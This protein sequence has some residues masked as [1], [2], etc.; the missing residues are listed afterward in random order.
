MPATTAQALPIK[1]ERQDTMPSN[2]SSAT[3]VPYDHGWERP[4]SASSSMDGLQRSPST[5]LNR[6]V[7][8]PKSFLPSDTS[9]IDPMLVGLG[10]AKYMNSP[11][12]LATPPDSGSNIAGFNGFNSFN[13]FNNFDNNATATTGLRD[14]ISAAQLSRFREQ[15]HPAYPSPADSSSN[16]PDTQ[17]AI[18]PSYGG[19]QSTMPQAQMPPPFHGSLATAPHTGSFRR[20]EQ[21]APVTAEHRSKRMRLSPMYDLSKGPQRYNGNSNFPLG[22]AYYQNA[23]QRSPQTLQYR[24]YSPA[25]SNVGVPLT[26]SSSSA[27][28]DENHA[29][30]SAKPSPAVAQDSPDLRRVSVNSLLSNDDDTVGDSHSEGPLPSF[31]HQCT[32]DAV[33]QT[34]PYG[35]DRGLPD[36]DCP[37][38]NDSIALD[39]SSNGFDE[40]VNRPTSNGAMPAAEFGFGYQRLNTAHDRGNYYAKPVPVFIP[41]SLEPLPAT[42]L[43]NPMNMLYFHHFLHHTA[44]ILVP[45]DC[46]ENPFKSIL[47]QSRYHNTIQ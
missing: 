34:V 16:F 46:S 1:I 44:R 13:S 45:H 32:T 30:S 15:I 18:G 9:A 33:T 2:A 42:L 26:P 22:S 25:I 35:W 38:N 11:N 4:P 10:D 24:P 43:E 27:A 19:Y 31:M 40:M 36:L 14:Q 47:P 23:Q 17:N 29:R 41:R 6:T 37:R 5:L 3:S 21:D 12:D 7:Y 8:Q 39:G 28:S 20:S